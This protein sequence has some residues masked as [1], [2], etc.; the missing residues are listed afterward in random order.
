MRLYEHLVRAEAD[1]MLTPGE[2]VRTHEL[3]RAKGWVN[4]K[5]LIEKR[6]QHVL[7]DYD[8]NGRF[9]GNEEEN[10]KP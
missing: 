8:L 6:W 5:R 10:W 7:R 2:I 9:Q 1:N 3:C 4:T